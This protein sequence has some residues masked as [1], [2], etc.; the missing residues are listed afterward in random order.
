MI[1]ITTTNFVDVEISAYWRDSEQTAITFYKGM[2]N[3][4]KATRRALVSATSINVTFAI[5]GTSIS[6]SYAYQLDEDGSVRIDVTYLIRLLASSSYALGFSMTIDGQLFET[7]V[8]MDGI[9]PDAYCSMI[10]MYGECLYQ[11]QLYQ[12]MILP[13]TIYYKTEGNVILPCGYDFQGYTLTGFAINGSMATISASLIKATATLGQSY[14]E[15]SRRIIQA[16]M[17][18]KTLV[19]VQC[20]CA[21]GNP[22]SYVTIMDNIASFVLEQVSSKVDTTITDLQTYGD[23][24]KSI[25]EFSEQITIGLRGCT[26]YD[27]AYYSLLLLTANDI[28]IDGVP[29][30]LVTKSA[31][32]PTGN[33]DKYNLEITLKRK[34]YVTI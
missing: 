10:S 17:N 27:Y 14:W 16:N 25:N 34:N 8:V 3:Y 19:N 23:G 18:E 32:I 26:A 24:Y 4:I 12:R 13:N 29:C 9:H 15:W 30:E 28:L 7:I 33:R 1:T 21:I 31:N 20:R 6:Y 22:A 11:V 5:I 2:H